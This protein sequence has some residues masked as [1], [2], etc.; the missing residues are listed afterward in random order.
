MDVHGTEWKLSYE[1]M[2]IETPIMGKKIASYPSRS[3]FSHQMPEFELRIN[4]NTLIRIKSKTFSQCLC[5]YRA[6]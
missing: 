6:I 4:F 1:I 3:P 2:S 5:V